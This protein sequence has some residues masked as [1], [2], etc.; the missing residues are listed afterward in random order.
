[1]AGE[2][3]E[4]RGGEGD[5]FFLAPRAQIADRRVDPTAPL[6]DLHVIQ[7]SGA[8][9]LFV[10]ARAAE[11]GMSM[12]VD[13]AGHQDAAPAIDRRETRITRFELL[14][15][16]D[17][18]DLAIVDCDGGVRED[19]SVAHLGAAPRAPGP[20]ARNYLRRVYEQERLRHEYGRAIT[21]R[22]RE[23]LSGACAS[24]RHA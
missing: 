22:T 3:H 17:G 7:A 13:E 5:Q 21:S 12:G 4:P 14:G 20:G 16:A 2:A 9:L 18:D 1:M 15:R 10:G 6:R 11:D 19:T 24:P 8:H 23:S